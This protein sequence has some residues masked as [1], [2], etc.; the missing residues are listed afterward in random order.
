MSLE[1]IVDA[2]FVGVMVMDTGE[3][4]FFFFILWKTP[5]SGNDL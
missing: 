5:F 1:I 4:L 3:D 2:I